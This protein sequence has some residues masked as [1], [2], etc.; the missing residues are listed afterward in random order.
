MS[1]M[2][3]IICSK[4]QSKTHK[5]FK[6]E[7]EEKLCLKTGLVRHPHNQGDF[8]FWRRRSKRPRQPRLLRGMNF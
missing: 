6:E 2:K 7:E 3:C 5:G 4:I 1:Y 8:L